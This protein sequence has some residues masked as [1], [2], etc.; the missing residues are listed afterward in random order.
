M[1]AAWEMEYLGV[2]VLATPTLC[3]RRS[4]QSGPIFGEDLLFH[5]QARDTHPI[6]QAKKPYHVAHCGVSE[7]D[8]GGR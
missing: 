6:K 1:H 3:F 2:L 8:Y 7:Q 4:A 5:R